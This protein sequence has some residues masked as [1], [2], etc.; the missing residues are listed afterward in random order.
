MVRVFGINIGRYCKEKKLKGQANFPINREINKNRYRK[1]WD[2]FPKKIFES[3]FFYV[4]YVLHEK[5]N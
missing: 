4:V 3:V 2:F 1:Y 5:K